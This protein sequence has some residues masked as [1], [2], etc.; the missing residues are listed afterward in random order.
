MAEDNSVVFGKFS[1]SSSVI[2]D[3]HIKHDSPRQYPGLNES[4]NSH[5]GLADYDLSK[6]HKSAGKPTF[7]PL[8]KISK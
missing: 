5:F 2:N 3:F 4:S 6:R 8:N 7:T 1:S